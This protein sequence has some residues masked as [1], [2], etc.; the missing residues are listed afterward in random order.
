M[1]RKDG[2]YSRT[3]V[4]TGIPKEHE[5]DLDQIE[6]TVSYTGDSDIHKAN[7]LDTHV[8]PAIKAAFP[9]DMDLDEAKLNHLQQWKESVVANGGFGPSEADDALNASSLDVIRAME[10]EYQAR[11]TAPRVSA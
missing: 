7:A 9:K 2:A 4:I 10:A 6:I 3:F 1:K 5:T 11:R 8:I